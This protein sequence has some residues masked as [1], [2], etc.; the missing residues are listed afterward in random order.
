MKKKVLHVMTVAMMAVAVIGCGGR[1]QANNAG[2]QT[3]APASPQAVAAEEPVETGTVATA[4]PIVYQLA[5]GTT[6]VLPHLDLSLKKYVIGI[7]S[8]GMCVHLKHYTGFGK[9]AA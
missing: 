8:G 9:L 5:D 4:L 6:K 2:G 1:G 3:E 7:W